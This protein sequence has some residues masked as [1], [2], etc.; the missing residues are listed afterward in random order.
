MVIKIIK[1]NS[2]KHD[3]VRLFNI[4]LF[5]EVKGKG[6]ANPYENTRMVVAAWGDSE[7][8]EILTQ[9]PTI[10]RASQRLVA[11]ISLSLLAIDNRKMGLWVRD[12]SQAYTQSTS[13]LNRKFYAN[14]PEKFR[15]KYPKDSILVIL[16]PLYG[17]LE[18][19]THW[20]LTY[21]NHHRE[22][23]LMETSTYDPCLLICTDRDVFGV[24][25][26]Q[27]DDT[28]ILDEKQFSDRE[29]AKLK[30]TA[31][32]KEHL[33]ANNPISFNGCIL[34]LHEDGSIDLRQKG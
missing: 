14:I 20:W 8:K 11:V 2:V 28:L 24:V 10:Q 13:L 17:I 31:K 1:Y 12:I 25:A 21:H 27:T 26:M 30:F 19:R 15:K 18:A 7:K 3:H 34:S 22:E 32:P 4:R 6:T 23:L 33:T 29:E 5:R 16:K 9:S